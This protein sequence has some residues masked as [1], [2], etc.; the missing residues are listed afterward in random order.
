M[1]GNHPIR[2]GS[3]SLVTTSL[4]TNDPQVGDRTT[5]GNNDYLFV[6]NACGEQVSIGEAVTVSGTSGYSC[7]VT[8]TTSADLILGVKQDATLSTGAYGW[9]MTRGFG[10]VKMGADFSATTGSPLVIAA[11]GRFDRASNATGLLANV[12]CKAI[13]GIASGTTGMALFA[14][15]F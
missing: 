3:V 8:T 15:H 10:Y 6:Y 2:F 5:V 12:T 14:S 1:Y 7:F 13:E 4:G 9:I 11:T